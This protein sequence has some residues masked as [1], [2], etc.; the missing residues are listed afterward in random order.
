[1]ELRPSKRRGFKNKGVLCGVFKITRA[2]NWED[3]AVVQTKRLADYGFGRVGRYP[4][5]SINKPNT[6]CCATNILFV[7]FFIFVNNCGLY[8]RPRGGVLFL[9][10]HFWEIL[11]Y[12]ASSL[13]FLVFTTLLTDG[14]Q[15]HFILWIEFD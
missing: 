9:L 4:F 5:P 7:L 11:G 12:S 3:D 15:F 1:M 8:L 13:S 2:V 14:S 6:L 10:E